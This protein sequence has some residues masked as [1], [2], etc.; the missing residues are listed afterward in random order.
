MHAYIKAISYSV[1]PT[2]D[3]KCRCWIHNGHSATSG[4]FALVMHFTAV[5][6]V[7][8]HPCACTQDT[9]SICPVTVTDG[10]D[11]V[12]YLLDGFQSRNGGEG[13]GRHFPDVHVHVAAVLADSQ[14][15]IFFRNVFGLFDIFSGLFNLRLAVHNRV[16]HCIQVVLSYEKRERKPAELIV[17]FDRRFLALLAISSLN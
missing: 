15:G 7:P 6:C 16:G 13:C 8:S 9:Q 4:W 1:L 17:S 14:R 12:S 10:G 3:W 11:H 5:Q 2:W